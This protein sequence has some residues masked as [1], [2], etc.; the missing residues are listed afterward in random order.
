MFVPECSDKRSHRPIILIIFSYLLIIY[1]QSKK[2]N[3]L[4]AVKSLPHTR[5]PRSPEH[6]HHLIT[7][8]LGSYLQALSAVIP[9]AVVGA[10]GPLVVAEAQSVKAQHTSHTVAHQA[11]LFGKF[12]I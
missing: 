9:A 5:T 11:N 1:Q 10:A 12:M 6:C 7:V 3:L 8:T 4:P 2:K